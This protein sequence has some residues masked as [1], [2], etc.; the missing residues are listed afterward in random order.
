[1]HNVHV[2]GLLPWVDW[3]R[4]L[5]P[6]EWVHDG[7]GAHAPLPTHAAA[8]LDA[9]LHNVAIGGS[10]LRVDCVPP[11]PRAAVRA[12]R[13][14]DARRRREATPGFTRSGVRLDAEG[15]VSL[16]PEALALQLGERVAA[17]GAGLTVVDAGCGAGGNAIGF[18]RAGCTVTAIETSASRLADAR[19]N[20]RIYG[21]DDRIRFVHGD[22][23]ALVAGLSGDVLFL[24]PP[25]GTDWSRSGMG[26]VDLPL[27]DIIVASRARFRRILLKLPP[28]FRVHELPDAR[29]EAIFG[30]GAGDNR[31]VKFLLVSIPGSAH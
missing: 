10:P 1:M 29:P 24:D 11:L 7:P 3:R 27:L 2:H 21:V 17:G 15:K 14:T 5:G 4:L 19:H 6:G 18:A 30:L 25:W 9:R 28:S 20:A 22:A 31:R 26:I 12:A 8:D 13:T 23:A 16:T